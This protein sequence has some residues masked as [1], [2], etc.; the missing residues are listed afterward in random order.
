MS[1]SKK[2]GGHRR[3]IPHARQLDYEDSECEV[4]VEGSWVVFRDENGNELRI[5]GLNAVG[6]VTNL[7]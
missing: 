6:D 1:D 5:D 2:Y 4:G 3:E 7:R